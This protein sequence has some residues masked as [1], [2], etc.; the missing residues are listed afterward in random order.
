MVATFCHDGRRWLSGYE[1]IIAG[2]DGAAGQLAAA[3]DAVSADRLF[4]AVIDLLPTSGLALDVGAGSGRDARWLKHRGLDVVAVEPAGGLRDHGAALGLDIRWV[5][6]RLPALDQVHR[7]ALSYDLITLSAVW[8]HVAPADRGRAFRKL[9]T[10]LRPGGLLVMT[11]RSGPAPA[12]RAM[13]PTSSGEVEGLARAYGLE[14]LKVVASDDL[15]GRHEVS[16][17]TIVLR[18]PDDGTGALP[19]VRGIV[20]GD[21]KS[22]TYKLALLRA[23]A[24]I[25]EQTPAAAMPAAGQE[26]AVE[27]PLGLVALMWIRMYLPLVRQGLPQAPRNSGPDGLGFAKAGFRRLLADQVDPSELRVGAV[28]EADRAAVTSPH[29]VVR[30]DC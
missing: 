29:R 1:Q 30:A 22:S 20:L 8:Q 11:L 27:V 10:L 6:D 17:T 7:L 4:A 25:A 13:Y 28:F 19:L 18:M 24:R 21:D 16:W 9:V 26:D 3:Y 5:D 2:Y 15:R 23:V 14:V 12:D